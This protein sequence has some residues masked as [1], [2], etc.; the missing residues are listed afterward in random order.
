VEIQPLLGDKQQASKLEAEFAEILEPLEAEAGASLKGW[1]R[2][3]CLAAFEAHPHGFQV[4]ASEA[5][6][7]GRNPI[8]LLVQMVKEGDH[9]EALKTPAPKLEAV[10]SPPLPRGHGVCFNCGRE[11]DDAFY[12]RGEWWCPEHEALAPA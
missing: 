8:A 9:L 5:L 10:P 7:R 12:I 1:G 3:K 4:C 11:S 6:G 2:R